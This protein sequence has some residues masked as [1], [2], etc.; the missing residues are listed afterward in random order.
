MSVPRG[1]SVVPDS[2]RRFVSGDDL[3]LR[4]KGMRLAIP[5]PDKPGQIILF[6]PEDVTVL[7]H[8]DFWSQAEE[9][10]APIPDALP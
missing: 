4:L 2:G 10:P 1:V 6:T 8:P 9:S 5:H 3:M 7:F